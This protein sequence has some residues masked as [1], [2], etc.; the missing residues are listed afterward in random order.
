LFESRFQG[1]EIGRHLLSSLSA[2]D[3]RDEKLADAPALKVDRNGDSGPVV[4][5]GFDALR[6]TTARMGPS[7]PRTPQFLGGGSVA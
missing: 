5:H 2:D 7:M 6:S 4:S 1:R 3:K